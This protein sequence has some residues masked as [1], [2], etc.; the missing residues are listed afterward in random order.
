M[1]IKSDIFSGQLERSSDYTF[2]GKNKIC[3]ISKKYFLL[4]FWNCHVYPSPAQAIS[5]PSTAQGG[6][7]RLPPL[8]FRPW[9]S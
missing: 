6:L 8:P 3:I 2:T 1:L 7:V 5:H 4:I 9:L